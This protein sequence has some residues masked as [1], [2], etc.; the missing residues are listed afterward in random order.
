MSLSPQNQYV[1]VVFVDAPLTEPAMGNVTKPSIIATTQKAETKWVLV[2][3]ARDDLERVD[4]KAAPPCRSD[5]FISLPRTIS[6]YLN[7]PQH[8]Q[9]IIGG[10]C[11]HVSHAHGKFYG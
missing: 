8:S 2:R 5:N 10:L 4:G 9:E 7:D 6:D 1:M 11:G 3:R